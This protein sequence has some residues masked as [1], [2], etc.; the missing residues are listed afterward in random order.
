M[1]HVDLFN[2]FLK[3]VVNLNTTRIGDLERTTEAIKKAVRE[4]EWEP[5]IS[6][7]MPQG[8]WAHKTI[9]RPVDAGEFDADL[10]VFVYPVDGWSAAKYIN[11]LYNVLKANAT[12]ANK[13]R[14]WS[15]CVT[16]TYASEQKVDV[17]PCIINR[18][19]YQRLEVC[20]RDTDKFELTEPRQFTDW[21]IE[22][23][24]YTGGNS[25]RKA[26][27]LI[28][29]LRDIK[30]TF[31]CS[32]VLLTTILGQRISAFDQY[33][34]EFA[35]TPTALKTLF[36]RMDDWAQANPSKPAVSNPFLNTENFADN[37]TDNQYANFRD[38]VNR[39]RGWID[40]AYAETSRNASIAK[41][42]RVFG[43]D[44]ASDVVIETAKSVSSTALVHIR[45]TA[46]AAVQFAGD[47]VMAVKLF[48]SR[49]LPP[50]FNRMPHMKQPRWK[51][52]SNS[53]SV[54]VRAELY[55]SK[56]FNRVGPIQSLDPV[57]AGNWIQF[58][59]VTSMGLPFPAN[60]FRVKWRITN[61]DQAAYSA[62]ALRGD[63]YDSDTASIRW[64][65]LQYRGVHLA[66]AFVIRKRD[67][68]LVGQS[69]PFRV[70]IDA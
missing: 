35:D 32:S 70:V 31:T 56:G 65:Q 64:E 45:E 43:E 49:A 20:N 68:A 51:A 15:H 57:G 44:F 7:W 53:V 38:V 2:D 17:A 14:R 5:T 29:Y 36:S 54:Q 23:N 55:R 28:K 52:A 10:L 26:A 33:G 37:W 47:L 25:F 46:A 58:T 11:E 8:S 30:T 67:D 9:I 27:R 24:G 48:G 66:E 18:D 13:V 19:G 21:I 50:E 41:W 1:K 60:E 3:E 63:F 22:R 69:A 42:R 6:S 62:R 39:Y 61:T 59:A 40:D 16:I 34:S 12:Y 4:S